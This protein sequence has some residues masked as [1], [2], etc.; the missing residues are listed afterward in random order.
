MRPKFRFAA[1]LVW[2]CVGALS[3]V[4]QAEPMWTTYHRDAQRSGYDPEAT[5]P[6]APTLAWQTVDLGA[7]IWSQPL[8]LG[9]RVYVA[10]VGDE[11]Y[12]LEASS[13]KIVWQTSVGTPVPSGELPCGDIQPTVGIVGTPVIDVATQ[14]IYMVA[15]T[16]NPTT[17]E[18]HHLLKG[19]SLADGKEVLSTSTDPPGAD[20]R[21]LLQ[22][23][24]LN[25]DGG[26]AV[27]GFGGN[28]GDCSDYQGTVVTVPLNGNPARFWQYRPAAPSSSGGA[29]WAPSGPA[30]DSAG[31]VYATTG[32]PDPPSGTTATVYDYSDSVVKLDPAQDFVEFPTTEPTS[33]LGWFKPPNWEEESNN[34]FDLSSA[35]PEL[36]PGGLLF[37]AG[38]D[39]VGYLIEEATMGSGAAAVYSHKV[40]GE[41]SGYGGSF[42]GDAFANGVLYIPCENGVQALAYDE[43][44]CAFTP[45]WQGPSDAVGP[46]IVSAGLVWTV[47]TGG[48]SGGGT[49]LYGLEP[50]TGIPRYTET[51]PSPV[52]DHFAS[53]SAAGGHLYVSTGSSVTAYQIAR[54]PTTSAGVPSL[55][56]AVMC[57]QRRG[58]NETN[59]SN[60]PS[61]TTAGSMNTSDTT[62]SPATNAT[63]PPPEHVGAVLRHTNL[64]ASTSGKVKIA[65]RCLSTKKL[66]R[67]TIDLQ[68]RIALAMANGTRNESHTVLIK[69]AEAHF[70]PTSGDFS[71]T[72]SLGR[73]AMIRL[74]RHKDRLTLL[75]TISSPGTTTRRVTAVL[76]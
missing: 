75:V 36:L 7:P 67:G 15:D 34:D 3:G 63:K 35:G 37:Q 46:P 45:L 51:L 4:A 74:R 47:A 52:D 58:T 5:E 62:A 65:L 18:I 17:K 55:A 26:D 25:I 2:L 38:K 6:V 43:Q 50:S 11:V 73:N 30:V 60:G 70:G 10:T 19:L 39:G 31:N 23:T 66:C 59:E 28:D 12:A 44:A 24:A 48:F 68:T 61:K 76:R 40:C 53:P 64:H 22:R 72:L 41:H 21:A 49:T 57:T 14:T 42:G 33:P 20:P 1:V 56:G 29:V 8:V 71:V 32:N 54:A 69:L 16:W 9:E 13:G 27:F